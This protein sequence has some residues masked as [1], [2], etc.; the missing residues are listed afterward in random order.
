MSQPAR[1][2]SRPPARALTGPVGTPRRTGPVHVRPQL[3][4]VD[5]DR[6][7]ARTASRASSR[8]SGRAR[9]ASS[10]R[11]PFV[12][13]VV[14]LL[15]VTALA[16]LALNTASGVDSLQAT[17][18]QAANE[19]QRQEV[20]QLEQQVVTGGTTAQ[21]AQ[22]AA[23]QGLVPA[24]TAGHL[25]V[26]PDGTSRLVGTPDPAP[27]PAPAAAPAAGAAPDG[28]PAAVPAGEGD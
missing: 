3:R 9:T 20:D 27:V 8:P 17:K 26:Q 5:A 24:G 28:A 22:R 16:L 14:G 25:V 12:L 23:Q 6:P 11:A 21:L 1:T 15:V 4:L 19:A 2:A 18:Q 7:A 10:R 13:L